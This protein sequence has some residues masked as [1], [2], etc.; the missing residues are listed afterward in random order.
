MWLNF[1]IN[2]KKRS[3]PNFLLHDL[4]ICWK[5]LR[6]LKPVWLFPQRPTHMQARYQ[7]ALLQNRLLRGQLAEAKLRGGQEGMQERRRRSTQH[8]VS[9][10]AESCWRLYSGAESFRWWLL[11]RFTQ[12]A[13]LCGHHHR[14]CISVLLAGWQSIRFQVWY[15]RFPWCAR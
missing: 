14:L 7:Q 5:P 6:I 11:D 2:I 4:I 9:S 15:T 12:R 8:W 13:K 10:W 1:Y 3:D